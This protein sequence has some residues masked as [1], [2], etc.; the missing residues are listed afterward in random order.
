MV[1]WLFTL[2]GVLVVLAAAL[3]FSLLYWGLA[4]RGAR[5][6]LFAAM[7]CRPLD[8]GDRYHERLANIVEE[9]RIATGGPASSA[10]PCAPSVSTR[11]PSA[12]C[13]AAG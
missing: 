10:S 4:Q 13:T 7:H 1:T 8:P 2:R 9:M 12:T 5:D 6:R 11:S 3:V